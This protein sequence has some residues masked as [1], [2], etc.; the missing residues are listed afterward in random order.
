MYKQQIFFVV[1]DI[2]RIC[3]F[4]LTRNKN[5]L[6]IFKLAYHNPKQI[7]LKCTLVK[8]PLLCLLTHSE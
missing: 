3:L 1:V 8:M 2:D 7:S 6:R 5:K 4:V